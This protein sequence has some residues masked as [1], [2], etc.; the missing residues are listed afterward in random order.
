[1]CLLLTRLVS[2][3]TIFVLRQTAERHRP[4]RKFGKP[5][6]IWNL[7][8]GIWNLGKFCL[9]NPESGKILLLEF[10]IRHKE[11][12]NPL[13]IPESRIQVLLAKSGIQ[14]LE[15]GIHGVQSRIKTI[16]DSLWGER[17]PEHCFLV[18][19]VLRDCYTRYFFVW[20]QRRK[21]DFSSYNIYKAQ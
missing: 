14:Y 20:F 8:S 12:R 11:S 6:G 5:S 18:M 1:M 10:G 19:P 16:L 13:T 7:E 9:W 3:H 17:Q 15:S 2:V 21:H 4:I